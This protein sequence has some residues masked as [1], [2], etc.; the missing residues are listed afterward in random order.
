VTVLLALSGGAASAS[1]SYGSAQGPALPVSAPFQ[2]CPAVYKDTSCGYLIDISDGAQPTVLVDSGIEFYEG[3][4]DVL[5]G[6]QNDSS[7]P[8]GSL[9]LGVPGSGSG[10]FAFDYDGM[11]N[12][13]AVPVPAECPFGPGLGPAYGYWGPDAEL[14]AAS[15]DDGSVTFPVPLQPGQYT[16]FALEAAPGSV[17]V[18]GSR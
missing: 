8:V 9:H 3:E 7:V 17:V 10:S 4:D 15:A 6:V 16:Y 1:A 13:R 11:C 14:T 5:V 18:A 12:P 2:Q